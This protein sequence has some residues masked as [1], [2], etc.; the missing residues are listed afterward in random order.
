MIK[1]NKLYMYNNIIH[2]YLKMYNTSELSP[3]MDDISLEGNNQPI[4]NSN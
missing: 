1:K 4:P 3:E 2:F